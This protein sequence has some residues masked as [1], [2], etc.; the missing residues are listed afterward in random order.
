MPIVEGNLKGKSY[1]GTKNNQKSRST[2]SEIL[3]HLSD[4]QVIAYDMF[5]ERMRV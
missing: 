5:L 1:E 4:V 3:A 2:H